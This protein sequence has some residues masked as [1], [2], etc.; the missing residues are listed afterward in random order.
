[1]FT[2]F[3]IG[4]LDNVW[5]SS[6]ILLGSPKLC[7]PHT[8][9]CSSHKLV[10]EAPWKWNMR[11][12]HQGVVEAPGAIYHNLLV[13]H[14]A[15]VPCCK[16]MRHLSA[17][18]GHEIVHSAFKCLCGILKHT[19]STCR[20]WSTKHWAP[21]HPK[22]SLSCSVRLEILTVNVYKESMSSIKWCLTQ[23]YLCGE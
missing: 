9:Y 5:G 12:G 14:F 10:L 7:L 16:M 19:L 17:S 11:C 4:V 22:S 18:S 2:Q 21:K 6:Y 20:V 23:T 15:Q 3:T 8:H 13:F 1:M